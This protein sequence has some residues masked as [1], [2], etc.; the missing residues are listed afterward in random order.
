MAH[1]SL[2]SDL[3][4]ENYVW[5]GFVRES[6]ANGEL[7]LWNPHL[8]AGVPF[9]AAG[10]ASVIYPLSLRITSCRWPAPTAGIP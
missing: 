9:F 10:Q 5:R 4:L 1:N 2:L 6:I 3:V 8:F 7:P